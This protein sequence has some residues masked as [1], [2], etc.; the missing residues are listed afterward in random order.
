MKIDRAWIREQLELCDRATEGPWGYE[1]TH[2][3]KRLVWYEIAPHVEGG[4]LDWDRE[5]CATADPDE[6][7]AA[8]IAVS[9]TNYP[10][11][12]RALEKAMELAALAEAS[13]DNNV[14]RAAVRFRRAL[15]EATDAAE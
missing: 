1:P 4:G 15:E 12:L 13:I 6:N 14:A 7:L 11:A 2:V 3:G 10:A 5:I 8:F 9:R